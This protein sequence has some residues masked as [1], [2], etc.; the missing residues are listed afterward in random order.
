MAI[1]AWK[2][3]GKRHW[4]VMIGGRMR[5]V[6]NAYLHRFNRLAKKEGIRGW[7]LIR[8]SNDGLFATPP[9]TYMNRKYP[10]TK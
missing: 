2:T 4:V 7:D 1:S 10:K 5:V 9:G 8:L 6:D 3:T